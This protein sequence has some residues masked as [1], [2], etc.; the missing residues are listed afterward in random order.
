MDPQTAEFYRTRSREW[1]GALPREWS[2][3]LDPF[4]DRLPPGA[5]VLELGCGD[6]RDAQ[7]MEMRGFTVDASDGVEQ[8]AA[9]ASE[10]LG[11]TIPAM[12]FGELVAER[13]YD[14]AWCHASLLHVPLGELPEV[15]ARVR[16]ALRKGG[17]FYASF[18]GAT[19][20]HR[21]NSR[22]DFGRLYSY[23]TPEDLK[24][25]YGTAGPWIEF[26]LSTGKGGSFGGA[27]TIWH[28]VIA[29]R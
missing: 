10:R 5:H 11:R 8:M 28:S 18:K 2:E 21:S 3:D 14:A 25:A 20:G 1:A 27:P 26:E 6:G 16:R 17:L 7:R 15:L 24:A 22:D 13:A 4:L 12:T 29:R 9:L 19:P 23:L